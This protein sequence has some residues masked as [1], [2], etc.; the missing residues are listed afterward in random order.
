MASG[1]MPPQDDDF[2][3]ALGEAA[4]ALEHASIQYVLMGGVGSAAFGRPRWTHDVDIFVRPEDAHGALEALAEAG[5]KTEERDPRWL[6]KAYKYDVLV[7]VIFRSS[8]N[9][10]LDDEM[11]ERSTVGQFGPYNARVIPPED[12]LVIKA[13][14]S[15]EHVAHHWHDALGVIGGGEL[16]WD[17][18]VRRARLHGTRRVLSLLV[19]GAA[20]DLGVPLWPIRELFRTAFA[21]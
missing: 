6:F 5:F 13:V 1:M 14:T 2:L 12:L 18:L 10:Y 3:R 9:I 4:E 17:Y 7:D 21:D 19:Y 16:D 15:D 11:L 8:G 20:D